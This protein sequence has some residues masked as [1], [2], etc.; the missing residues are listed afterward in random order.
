MRL[1]TLFLCTLLT[2]AAC[3]A[4][5]DMAQAPT[6]SADLA[7]E[8]GSPEALGVLGLLGHRS[9]TV[10][11]LDKDVPLDK[12]AAENLINHRDGDDG[13]FGTADDRRYTSIAQV[14][15]VPWVG[16]K[17]IEQLVSYARDQ[18]WVPLADEVI[19]VWDGVGFTEAEAAQTLAFA[20]SASHGLLDSGLRLDRR[21][22]RSIVQARPI[23]SVEALSKLYYVGT[24]ALQTLKEH[25]ASVN[26]YEDQFVNDEA[27]EI[28]DGTLSGSMTMVHVNGAP[29]CPV[30]VR[31]VADVRHP[32][33]QELQM[34][35]TSPSGR[36]WHILPS[37]EVLMGLGP[38]KNVNGKWG[39]QVVDAVP[40]NTGEIYG[41]ALEVSAVY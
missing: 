17:A 34:V 14:D 23:E 31:L 21:A 26:I 35:L 13:V 33:P 16:P 15:A 18:G 12:R 38:I 3:V 30:Q 20:N 36:T 4:P 5:D 25:A 10:E 8:E 28:P 11:V 22:A 40:V 32:A 29:D 6:E 27:Q 19:G 24:S 2:S 1:N 41:W 37:Q 7:L 9:T 39:L